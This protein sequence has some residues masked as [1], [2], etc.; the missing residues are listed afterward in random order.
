AIPLQKRELQCTTLIRRLHQLLQYRW[1]A[2]KAH[3]VAARGY[4]FQNE[5]H[6]NPWEPPANSCTSRPSGWPA[7]PQRA[8]CRPSEIGDCC[9]HVEICCAEE[10]A[11]Q[12]L[13]AGKQHDHEWRFVRP[14]RRRPTALLAGGEICNQ[15]W[16]GEW[17]IS[18]G[19]CLRT[20][21]DRSILAE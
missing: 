17:H 21:T 20:T 7:S 14:L 1:G 5:P 15:R 10:A 13:G 11:C 2:L 18:G 19:L 8:S 16:R 9:T 6:V 3:L 12:P 4:A